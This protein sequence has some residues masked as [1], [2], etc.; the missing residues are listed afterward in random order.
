MN[1]KGNPISFNPDQPTHFYSINDNKRKTFE[2]KWHFTDLMKGSD[3]ILRCDLVTT[4]RSFNLNNLKN[5]YVKKQDQFNWQ[6]GCA[7]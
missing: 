2:S 1:D 5:E 6:I 7:A 4:N 3:R